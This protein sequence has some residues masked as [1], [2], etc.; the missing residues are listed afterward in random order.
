MK[1]QSDVAPD[2]AYILKWIGDFLGLSDSVS[3]NDSFHSLGVDSAM[4]TEMV[5]SLGEKLSVDIDPTLVYDCRTVG[6]FAEHV[7]A[8]VRGPVP[9]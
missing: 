9:G 8:L 1:N 3:G 7:D 6:I 5:F 2:V 4:A